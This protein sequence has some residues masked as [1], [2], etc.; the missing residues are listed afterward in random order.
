MSLISQDIVR[1]GQILSSGDLVAI[2]TETVYGLAGNAL[3]PLAVAK[4]FEAKNRP[5]FDPLIVHIGN[6]SQLNQFTTSVSEKAEKLMAAFW[7]G[8]LTLLFNKSTLI[9]DIVT[10]GLEKVAIR[11]P[12]H[13]MTLKLLQSLPFPLAAP[14][15][16]PFGYVSPTEA[17]HVESHLGHVVPMILDGG[18]CGVGVEST[19]VDVGSFPVRILRLGGIT[20]EQIEECLN[21]KVEIQI[22][23]SKPSAPGML[24]SHYAPRKPMFW[25]GDA[26]L[27]NNDAR[28]GYLSF[29][30][31]LRGD[32]V[33][34]LS[35]KGDLTEA[36]ARLFQGMRWLDEQDIDRIEVKRLPEQGLGRAMNDRLNRACRS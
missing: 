29:E 8:P 4:I 16:N 18:P 10:S 31:S 21:E 19:I 15:A 20:V 11:M 24:E 27:V 12:N 33:F 30:G 25:H 6:V 34:E 9:P 22:S 3:D 5:F 13:P 7:P 1:A 28:T 14:S 2:P 26:S 35:S 32:I 36:A 17:A 23:S